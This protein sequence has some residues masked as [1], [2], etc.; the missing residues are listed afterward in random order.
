[1]I[2]FYKPNPR[3]SGS[4]CSFYRTRDGSLMFS[5]I[6]QSSWNEQKK[7]GSFQ[8]NKDN[9]K[10]NVKI[11]LSL[12][13]AAG[14]IDSIEKDIESKE[15]HDSQNQTTQIRLAPYLDKEGQKKG[16][17]LGV[18][19]TSK[20]TQEKLSFI[21]GLTFKEARLLK[22]YLIYVINDSFENP[23]NGKSQD[24]ESEGESDN[25]NQN[26]QTYQKKQSPA[27]EPNSVIDDE[28]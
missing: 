12:A 2:Q 25:G 28:W 8:A 26:R 13:E 19:K 18:N 15:Y 11:K 14:F 23:K 21:I 27:S 22:Q 1:M 24:S 5:M 9:P 3:N 17:S 6:K 16:F 10:G 20:D 4:A 7:T